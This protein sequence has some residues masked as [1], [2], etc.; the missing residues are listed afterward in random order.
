MQNRPRAYVWR[1]KPRSRR[2]GDACLRPLAVCHIEQNSG[3]IVVKIFVVGAGIGGLS[4][5]WALRERGHSVSVF[6]KGPI[7]NPVSSSW[8]EHRMT[9]HAYGRLTSYARM[10]PEAFR[11]WDRMWQAIG[12]THYDPI[13]A[14]YII[15]EDNDWC[16]ETSAS[17]DELGIGYRYLTQ[18]EFRDRLPMVSSHNVS[19]V[20][21]TDGAGMLHA[22][23][24]LNGLCVWLSQ[25][26]V[27]LAAYTP[28]EEIDA[29]H[30]RIRLADGWVEAD[31]VVVA[32]GA[33]VL[34]LVPDLSSGLNPSRQSVLY[35]APPK[36]YASAWTKA[37]VIVDTSKECENYALP[38]RNGTRLKIGD[39]QFTKRGLPDD[40]RLASD[41]DLIR[42]RRAIAGGYNNAAEYSEIE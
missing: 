24:V 7:P 4:L 9:R 22:S 1:Q 29:D 13:G 11:R 25:N 32:A 8:D 18:A 20:L 41:E 35:L 30:G 16:R 15:R 5:A 12:N 37:P 14:A 27:R 33:W 40:T 23:R 38:P 2:S 26:D 6:E 19:R 34:H 39:H 42:L 36:Q 17:L 10:M 3:R 21:E 31:L 28:V